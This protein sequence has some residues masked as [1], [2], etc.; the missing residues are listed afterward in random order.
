MYYSVVDICC[1]K[2]QIA[3]V[4]SKNK[5]WKTVSYTLALDFSCLFAI[6]V[7]LSENVSDEKRVK[8]LAG[9]IEGTL[10]KKT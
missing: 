8:F 7:D 5:M 4:I 9:S 6:L 1:Q 10:E 2:L 3:M